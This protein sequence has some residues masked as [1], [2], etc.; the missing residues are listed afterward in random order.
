MEYFYKKLEI[1]NTCNDRLCC[2]GEQIL[3]KI[4]YYT[5]FNR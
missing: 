3:L 2:I 1:E 5:H 4:Q